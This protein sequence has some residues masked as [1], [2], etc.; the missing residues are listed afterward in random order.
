MNSGGYFFLL[1]R[2]QAI[3]SLPRPMMYPPSPIS[4]KSQKR[5]VSARIGRF[6]K[7]P[8]RTIRAKVS[9]TIGRHDRCSQLPRA[10]SR[11]V[12]F[13][14]SI[15]QILEFTIFKISVSSC[16]FSLPGRVRRST[17]S[18]TALTRLV[19]GFMYFFC[20]DISRLLPSKNSSVSR[21]DGRGYRIP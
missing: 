7:V 14:Y 5:E 19:T 11:I 8:A 3:C 2:E 9:I 12:F 4:S 18:P 17:T 1:S 20:L 10:S 13:V 15:Y 6:M 21:V 16:F